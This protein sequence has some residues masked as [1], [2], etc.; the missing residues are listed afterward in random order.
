MTTLY[1]IKNCDT[2]RKARRWLDDNNHDHTFLDFR[3][4][5]LE[6]KTLQSFA[7]QIEKDVLV[8]KR[9][10]TWKQLSDSQKALFD[11]ES[12]GT[13]ALETLLNNPTLLK[14]PVLLT[15]KDIFVG[16]KPE[17]YTEIFA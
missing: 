15:G 14:R 6:M 7:T 13:E 2:V 9:S 5:G 17:R 3:V 12:L 8:N 1:G 10:T 11:G 4:D 16:F